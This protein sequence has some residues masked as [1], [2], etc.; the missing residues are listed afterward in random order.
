MKE[1]LSLRPLELPHLLCG[2]VWPVAQLWRASRRVATAREARGGQTM[3][4]NT[5]VLV[6]CKR[7]SVGCGESVFLCSFGVLMNGL[8][9]YLLDV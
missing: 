8:L 2:G 6:A 5:T 7:A 4:N 1:V 9:P 3:G